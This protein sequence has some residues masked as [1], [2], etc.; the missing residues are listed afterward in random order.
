ML[1][2]KKGFGGYGMGVDK[3]VSQLIDLKNEVGLIHRKMRK[4]LEQI[5][6]ELEK[7]EELR[8]LIG[9]FKAEVVTG[10]CGEPEIVVHVEIDLEDAGHRI[11]KFI[12]ERYGMLLGQ[13][14]TL[15]RV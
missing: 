12:E 11:L 5:A 15:R 10:I 6:K 9:D 14:I 3:R 8:D 4:I 2:W 13:F 7:S 1:G